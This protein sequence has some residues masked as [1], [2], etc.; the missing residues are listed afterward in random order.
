MT[1]RDWIVRF[2][3]SSYQGWGHLATTSSVMRGNLLLSIPLSPHFL[4]L[5]DDYFWLVRIRMLFVNATRPA[6]GRNQK[7]VQNA[8][9]W[10]CFPHALTVDVAT[11]IW[12]LLSDCGKLWDFWNFLRAK[13]LYPHQKVQALLDS[14]T[15]AF[16]FVK[17][18]LCN[19]TLNHWS[20]LNMTKYDDTHQV[21][22]VWWQRVEGPHRV[23]GMTWNFR[24]LSAENMDFFWRLIIQNT[25]QIFSTKW[26]QVAWSGAEGNV[27]VQVCKS[28]QSFNVSLWKAG[29]VC[30]V[31]FSDFSGMCWNVP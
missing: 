20:I 25:S 13:V 31:P 16:K 3:N 10:K 19:M 12:E 24:I 14:E 29:A 6:F 23:W 2:A 5:A 11:C 7:I 1:L 17:H 30:N 26:H 18:S 21:C 4:L 15:E 9:R 28:V 27:N 8:S 22:P